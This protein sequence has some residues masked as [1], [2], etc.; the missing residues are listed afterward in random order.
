MYVCFEYWR[1]EI[2]FKHAFFARVYEIILVCRDIRIFD[3]RFCI[4]KIE[5]TFVGYKKP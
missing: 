4:V 3:T 1:A 2:N 5:T